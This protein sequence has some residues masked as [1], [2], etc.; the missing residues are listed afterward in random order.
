MIARYKPSC[1]IIACSVSPRICRQMNLYWGVTP[2]WIPRENSAEDLFDDAIKAAV[3]AGYIKQGDA[4]VLTA[5]LPLGIPGRTNMIR[6][7]EV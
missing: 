2:L 3:E 6:V 1:P 4:V 7:I 5:G